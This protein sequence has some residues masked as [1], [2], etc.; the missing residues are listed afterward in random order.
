VKL[1]EIL[2]EMPMPS[3]NVIK[4]EWKERNFLKELEKVLEG[5]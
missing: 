1:H 4:W 2:H 3:C 5:R